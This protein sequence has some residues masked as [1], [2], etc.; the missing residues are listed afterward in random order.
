MGVSR[1]DS[2]RW[3]RRIALDNERRGREALMTLFAEFDDV[4]RQTVVRLAWCE[5]I[6]SDEPLDVPTIMA[7]VAMRT[8]HP[9]TLEV[10]ERV[11]EVFLAVG[12]QLRLVDGQLP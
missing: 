4:E 3:R 2:M 6:A 1:G 7:R 9:V 10:V 5:C 8:R 12:P 11:R